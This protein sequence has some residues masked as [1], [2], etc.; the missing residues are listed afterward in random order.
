MYHR[1]C[2]G[3]IVFFS[4]HIIEVVEN[5]CTRIAIIKKG[6][7]MLDIDVKEAISKYGNLTDVYKK[8]VLE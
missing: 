3:N 2:K 4:S 1:P 8:Y 6:E 5:I 7:L